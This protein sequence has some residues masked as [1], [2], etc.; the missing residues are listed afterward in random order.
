MFFPLVRDASQALSVT[1]LKLF[2]VDSRIKYPFL[3]LPGYGVG[4]VRIP[5]FSQNL[6]PKK[7][8]SQK[9]PDFSPIDW[10]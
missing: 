5:Q 3:F 2:S 7:T 6:M 8:L 9:N 4:K 10:R 1:V